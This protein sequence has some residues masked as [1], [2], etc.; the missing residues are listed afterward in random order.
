[1]RFDLIQSL[2]L[3]GDAATPNDDRMGSGDRLAWVIDGATD[4]GPPG[5]LGPRG[6]AAWLAI[7]A[8]AAFAA[9]GD[10]PVAQV[11]AA[12]FA[13]IAQRYEAQRTRIPLGR[14]ELPRA[15]FLIARAG[16]DTV[17]YGWLGDCVGLLRSGG[18]VVRIG[19]P[20]DRRDRETAHAASLAEHGLGDKPR[21]GPVLDSLR[22]ARDRSEN[23]VL[24]VEAAAHAVRTGSVTAVA[25]DD[26][27][28]MTDGV[29][30]LTDAYAALDAAAM[31]T[32]LDQGGLLAIA[33]RLRTIEAEDAACT[34]YPRFKRSDD[35]TAI[36]L[37]VAD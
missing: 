27:L 20:I 17:D 21:A 36:W 24:G 7:E 3:A 32:L 8:D 4:L 1:M 28:L 16:E 37:R 11:C 6:G 35:A 34:R 13:R 10:A 33:A 12:A 9:A 14:W 5:L 23:H 29:S 15:S 19:E 26:L 22:A 31:M 25:G 18:E 30:V 2:S